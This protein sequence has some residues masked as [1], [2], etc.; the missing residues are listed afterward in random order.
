MKIHLLWLHRKRRTK[1]NYHFYSYW[2]VSECARWAAMARGGGWETPYGL[3]PPPPP[4]PRLHHSAFEAHSELGRDFLP[5]PELSF[6]LCLFCLSGGAPI[7]FS[8]VCLVPEWTPPPTKRTP[9]TSVSH[10][11]RVWSHLDGIGDKHQHVRG[12]KSEG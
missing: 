12:T 5:I 6:V 3:C 9:S 7:P 1:E 11:P 4:S 10:S 2:V 8:P